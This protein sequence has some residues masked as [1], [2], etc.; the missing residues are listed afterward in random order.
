MRLSR[1]RNKA[2]EAGACEHCGAL[3]YGDTLRCPQCHKFPIKM[4]RCSHCQ[5]ISAQNAERCWKCG[6][7]FRPDGDYL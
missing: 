1:S 5:C 2:S 3:T 6:R 4:H 7:V